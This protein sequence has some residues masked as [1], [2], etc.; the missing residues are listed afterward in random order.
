MQ[1]LL[2]GFAFF[3]KKSSFLL[4][5]GIENSIIVVESGLKWGKVVDVHW[6]ISMEALPVSLSSTTILSIS[7]AVFSGDFRVSTRLLKKDRP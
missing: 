7:F 5:K 3:A 2:T 4:Y 1:S 6:S